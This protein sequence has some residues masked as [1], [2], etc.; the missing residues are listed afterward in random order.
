[1]KP[2]GRDNEGNHIVKL[3]NDEMSAWLKLVLAT[4]GKCQFDTLDHVLD[5]GDLPD[6]STAL[7]CVRSYSINLMMLN[8][9][10]IMIGD[11]ISSLK[12]VK[13]ANDA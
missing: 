2:I 8:E 10:H 13:E 9:A 4:E 7:G 3:T 1:M 11:A 5:Y 6:M 12:K